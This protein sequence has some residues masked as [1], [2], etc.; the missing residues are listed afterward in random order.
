MKI[1]GRTQQLDVLIIDSKTEFTARFDTGSSGG[2]SK[3]MYADT[4]YWNTHPQ[5]Q[6]K[7]GYLYI[8]SDYDKDP[9]G[10]NLPGFKIGDGN[11]YVVDLPFSLPPNTVLTDTTESWNS[12]PT[13]V[14]SPGVIYIYSDA[15]II[16]EVP[17]PDFKIGDGNSYLIDISFFKA[18]LYTH[19]N[20]DIRHIT[21]EE[22][23]F[24]NNKN[25]CYIDEQDPESLIF[26]IL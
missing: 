20:D 23:E 17:Y 2:A 12:N 8:Y 15:R 18:D 14:S 1:D 4:E 9:E 26:T 11:S 19:I 7:P 10:R 25:R 21:Q 3:I 6:S 16:D 22:R 24:W 5:L 13:L